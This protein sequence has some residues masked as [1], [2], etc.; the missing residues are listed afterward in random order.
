M[1]F[2]QV[3][4]HYRIDRTDKPKKGLNTRFFFFLI[5]IQYP[6]IVLYFAYSLGNSM[7]SLVNSKLSSYFIEKTE[8]FGFY[9]EYYRME[10]VSCRSSMPKRQVGM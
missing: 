10:F 9:L 8:K 3:V 1:T 5:D 6:S 4:K 7:F 2:V